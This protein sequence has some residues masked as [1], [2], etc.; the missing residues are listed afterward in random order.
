MIPACFLG[1]GVFCLGCDLLAR[2]LF[3]PRELSISTVTAVLGAPV[4][5]LIMAGK[6][7]KGDIR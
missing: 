5:I 4:V 3:A 2:I 1:G 7:Q 6:K